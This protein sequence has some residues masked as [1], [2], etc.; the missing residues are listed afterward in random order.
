VRPAS[1]CDLLFLSLNKSEALFSPS[2][3]YRDLARREA[4]T[5]ITADRRLQPTQQLTHQSDQLPLGEIIQGRR[6][7]GHSW[8]FQNLGQ[9]SLPQ[10]RGAWIPPGCPSSRASRAELERCRWSGSANALGR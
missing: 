3:R 4:A 9:R 6:W 1:Q 8:I 10:L 7:W 5:L 2:T